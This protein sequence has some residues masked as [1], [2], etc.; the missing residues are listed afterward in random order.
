[1]AEKKR[2]GGTAKKQAATGAKK[3]AAEKAATL[4]GT[5]PEWASTSAIA[6]MLGKTVRRI[7]QLTQEGVLETE[8]PPGGGARKYRTCE[9]IQK[10]I[11][12]IEAKAQESGENSR[13]TELALKK[14]EAENSE[15]VDIVRGMSISLTD[16]PLLLQSIQNGGKAALGQSVPKSAS[17]EMEVAE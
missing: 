16:L 17:P 7:Q 8:V 9:T 14:L 12:Y 10:Y 5:V 6:Q 11:A 1:M 13:A 2:T 3:K 15:I 4:S